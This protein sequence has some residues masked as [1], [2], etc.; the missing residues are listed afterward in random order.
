MKVAGDREGVLD[1]GEPVADASARAAEEGEK[2]A[3]Y[4]RDVVRRL[5]D[6]ARYPTL[7]PVVTTTGESQSA[8][9]ETIARRDAFNILELICVCTPK[10]LGSV[11]SYD[12]DAEARALGSPTNHNQH[13]TVIAA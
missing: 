11:H 1:E 9:R 7:W 8:I 12:R 3:P 13:P 10:V 2:V 5:R 6:A 4:T